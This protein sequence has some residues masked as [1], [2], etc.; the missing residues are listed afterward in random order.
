MHLFIFQ[1]YLHSF[2]RNECNSNSGGI[3]ILGF[4]NNWDDCT[5]SL[6]DTTIGPDT[7]IKRFSSTTFGTLPVDSSSL[8]EWS[9]LVESMKKSDTLNPL[10]MNQVE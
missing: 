6:A 1:S 5:G 2:A 10:A 3:K 9:A 4:G 7:V 8:K